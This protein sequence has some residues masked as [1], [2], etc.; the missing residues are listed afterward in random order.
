MVI[1]ELQ[2]VV[3]IP[4]F[5]L[6][7]AGVIIIVLAIVIVIVSFVIIFRAIFEVIAIIFLSVI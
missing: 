3:I 7:S 5:Q 2:R 6:T 1:I 4:F